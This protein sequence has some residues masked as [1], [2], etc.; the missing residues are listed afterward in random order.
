MQN[1]CHADTK[2]AEAGNTRETN[3]MWR[4]LFCLT[5]IFCSLYLL[6]MEYL[7]KYKIYTVM[8]V[9]LTLSTSE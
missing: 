2:W 7:E 8:A 5:P 9:L 6:P 4:R 1:Q 3:I